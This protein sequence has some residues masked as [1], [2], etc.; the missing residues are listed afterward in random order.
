MRHISRSRRRWGVA[1]AAGLLTAA[2]L[3]ACANPAG[4]DGDLTGGWAA[5]GA[6]TGF[7][8]A[9]ET[10]HLANFAAVGARSAYE[11]VDCQ[12]KHRTETVYVGRYGSPAAEATAPPADGTSGARQA[13]DICDRRTTAY[14][15]APWR[16]ARL[17]IGVTQ[18]TKAAWTG[19]ARWYRCEVLES[20]SVEDDGGLVQRVGTLRNAL[21]QP[22]SPLLLTCYAV[23]LD[24]VG[25]IGTMPAAPCAAAHNAEFVGVW[26]AGN[27]AYPDT[28]EQWAEFHDGCR[29]LIATYVDVPDDDD[30]Q[31]RAGVVSLPGGKDVWALGDRGVRCYLWVDANALTSSLKGKGEKAL[32]VRYQ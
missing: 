24:K 25:K 14:V 21:R 17:W 20:S 5:I 6:P 4:V 31:Y 30:L 23:Q 2:S 12:I 32:P 10:C 27:R 11:Q 15:G 1:V 19:G 28:P 7:T 16:T 9:P 26:D 8:P 13:Y 22:K 3:T 29:A 18:P